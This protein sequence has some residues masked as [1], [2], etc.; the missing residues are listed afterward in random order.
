VLREQYFRA[1][2]QYT[3][4]HKIDL[5]RANLLGAN[6]SRAILQRASLVRTVL[7]EADLSHSV[8]IGC[9]E[10]DG[11]ECINANFSD[12]IIDN[13]K[14]IDYLKKHNAMKVPPAIIRKEDLKSELKERGY[15]DNIIEKILERTI[16]P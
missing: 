5:S 6:L 11:L 8:I 3:Y 14:L 12:A 9:T 7:S 10:Y 16:L 13:E 4:L 1:N 15:N 2:L